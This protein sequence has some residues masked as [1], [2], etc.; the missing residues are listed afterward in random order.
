MTRAHPIQ[1]E[2]TSGEFSPLLEG[3]LNLEKR[4]GAGLLVQNL[5]P[6][7][8]G[9]LMRR[10]RTNFVKEVKDSSKRTHLVRFE[11]STEQ[12]YQIEFGDQYLRFYRNNSIITATAQNVTG[13]TKANPAILTYSGSDTY[14]NGEEVYISGVVGM[15]ELNGKFFKVANLNAGAN[16]FELQDID[17]NAIDS[18]LYTSYSS[19]G[20]VAEV[21][22]IASPYTQA[23]LFDSN[24]LFQVMYQQKADGIYL[25]H[26]SYAPRILTRTGHAAWALTT[27]IFEDGPY[28]ALNTTTT[29][30]ALSGTSGSVTVTASAITGIN[31]DTGFQTTD[32]G[33]TIRWKDP[34]NNWTWLNITA[35]TSTTEV[36]AIVSGVVASAG[37]ATVNWR[38]GAYSGT[39]GYPSV[40]SFFQDRMVVA[41]NRDYPDRWDMTIPGGYSD[42]IFYFDP[43]EPNGTVTDSNGITGTLQSGTVNKIV[44]MSANEK[45]LIIITVSQEWVI[46]PD[47]NNGVIT[48]TNATSSPVSSIGGA[49]IKTLDIESGTVFV[50]RSR[51]K[52][53]DVVY[54]FESDRLKPR[55]LTLLSEHITKGQIVGTAYQQEPINCVWSITGNGLLI[56]FTYYPDQN[57]FGWHRHYIGGSFADGEAVVESVSAI[58]S[59]DGSRDELWIIVK[60]TING[61]TRRYVEYMSPHYD[62]L[63]ALEDSAC[64]DCAAIYD[65]A[66]TS[67]VTGLDHLEGETVRVMVDGKSHPD[68]VVI[69]GRITLANSRTGAKI[70]I[71]LPYKWAFKSMQMEAGATDGTAQGKTKRITGLVLRL[72]NTLGLKYGESATGQLDE[73]DFGQGQSYDETPTLFSGDTEFLRFPAGYGQSGHIYLESDGVFPAC[74][75]AIMPRVMTYEK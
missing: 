16:T 66:A 6:L 64:V 36:T 34:A 37:T 54:S 3:H 23:D 33:R 7:K 25:F 55:D 40:A 1:T 57:V 69:S 43:T 48:P 14:A 29:T 39:T 2:F 75:L 46:R 60:R 42:L 41:S 21:Y 26:G 74:V 52:L 31:N 67:A 38:L 22:T 62:D 4:S 9:A 5:L 10:G 59:P 65:G 13:V 19:G 18:T 49:Y 45:G 44:A 27:I 51:R 72:L 61:V 28:L 53:L 68:L 11:F 70:I 12:A 24:G 30:L 63:F 8:Q 35:W 32:I 73:Y 71:G 47:T 50:Q 17:G 20:S 15:T 58:P 56:G